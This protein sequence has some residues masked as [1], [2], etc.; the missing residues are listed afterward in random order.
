MGIV[1]QGETE[2][3][4][5]M[6][7]VSG[8]H[9]RWSF[10]AEVTGILFQT[11]CDIS[12]HQALFLQILGGPCDGHILQGG[13][14]SQLFTLQLHRT[15][16]SD[17]LPRRTFTFEQD[18]WGGRQPTAALRRPHQGNKQSGIERTGLQ[19]EVQRLPVILRLL[20]HTTCQHDLLEGVQLQLR[21]LVSKVDGVVHTT[22]A[23]H[24]D[25]IGDRD[26][27]RQVRKG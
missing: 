20:I 8:P 21:M 1:G 17:G 26:L 16:Q 24:T 27:G 25:A 14:I 7:Q 3:T 2:V 23:R 19:E 13:I 12:R 10:L 11:L 18:L 4:A 22:G 9:G 15:C 5:Q 6:H